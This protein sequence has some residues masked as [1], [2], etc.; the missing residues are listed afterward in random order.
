MSS[1]RRSLMG[2]RDISNV[3]IQNIDSN[4]YIET[5]Y[6]PNADTKIEAEWGIVDGG[7]LATPYCS[8]KG[9]GLNGFCTFFNADHSIRFQYGNTNSRIGMQAYGRMPIF[10]YTIQNKNNIYYKFNHSSGSEYEGTTSLPYEYF[11]C[12]NKLYLFA[13][14][15][16]KSV[17]YSIILRHVVISE[18]DTILFDFTPYM[19]NGTIGMFDTI[20]KQFYNNSGTG[21]GFKIYEYENQ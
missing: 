1:F 9:W 3:Y 5:P 13:M 20:N 10:I 6:Y 11:T 15:D 2:G 4:T 18:N 16:W 7:F 12:E 21:L 19:H 14:Q 8:R 17:E